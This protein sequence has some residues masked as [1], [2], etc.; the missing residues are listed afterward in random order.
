MKGKFSSIAVFI[1]VILYAAYFIGSTA[2]VHT[3]YFPTYSITHSHP[4]RTAP[5]KLPAHTHSQTAFDTIAQLNQIF[6]EAASSFIMEILLVL[7]VVFFRQYL[8]ETFIRSVRFC[9]LR[10]P[11]VF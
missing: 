7:L 8:T 2:F 1:L 5:G 3:H 6:T 10:A 9:H 11:P 4:F